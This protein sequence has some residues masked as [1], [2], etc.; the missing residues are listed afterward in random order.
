[1]RQ[2]SPI[3]S[4]TKSHKLSE[5]SAA[6]SGSIMQRSILHN[7]IRTRHPINTRTLRFLTGHNPHKTSNTHA[8]SA[9]KIQYI[10]TFRTKHPI[11][12]HNL[13]KTSNTHAQSARHPT[14]TH[15]LRLLKGHNP[16]KTC[17]THAQSAQNI[18]YTHTFYTKH[19]IHAHNP[20]KIS[21][22][23]NIHNPN[24]T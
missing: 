16:H 1:M 17:N 9:Q 8:Q 7:P 14:H 21:M 3:F 5:R 11:H 18:Q 6:P 19:P 24:K 2:R 12:M 4:T 10:R 13:H 20:Q 23:I 22:D 15:T